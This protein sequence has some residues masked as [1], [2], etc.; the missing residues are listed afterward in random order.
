[1]KLPMPLHCASARR[2]GNQGRLAEA[3]QWGDVIVAEVDLNKHMYWSS[4]G[5]FKNEL[6]RQRP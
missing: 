1:M 3:K 5:D 2:D 6:Q 4:L